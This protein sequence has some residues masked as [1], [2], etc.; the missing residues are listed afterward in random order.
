[1][2]DLNWEQEFQRFKWEGIYPGSSRK[3][4]REI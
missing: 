3:V 4:E 2:V 1:M